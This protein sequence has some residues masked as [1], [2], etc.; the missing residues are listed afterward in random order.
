MHAWH[1]RVLLSVVLL[2]CNTLGAYCQP[3]IT[4]DGE[5]LKGNIK[6]VKEY[7]GDSFS[8]IRETVYTRNSINEVQLTFCFR[9]NRIGTGHIIF[10][11]D[12]TATK[13]DYNINNRLTCK[14]GYKWDDRGRK[15]EGYT[16]FYP[17]D[18]YDTTTWGECI[19]YFQDSI[20]D[21][22]RYEYNDDDMLVRETIQSFGRNTIIYYKYDMRGKKTEEAIYDEAFES[23]FGSF[24]YE[25]HKINFRTTFQYNNH[26]NLI[27]STRYFF[28]PTDNMIT[29][30]LCKNKIGERYIYAHDSDS[31]CTDA[32][33]YSVYKDASEKELTEFQRKTCCPRQMPARQYDK[34]GNPIL[35]SSEDGEI[36]R[37]K[38]IY[39]D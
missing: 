26:N 22:H 36:H 1:I 30:K 38:I 7:I 11:S 29:N 28:D 37:R 17:P 24:L 34:H 23:D 6:Q 2:L 9:G 12:S 33:S 21:H 27:E 16:V 25:G 15:T 4:D 14:V 8:G 19:L 5:L 39:S 10:H 20:I 18:D 3:W 35:T 32:A 13:T 31:H